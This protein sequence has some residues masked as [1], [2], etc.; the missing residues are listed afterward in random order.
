VEGVCGEHGSTYI[1]TSGRTLRQFAAT[2]Q[3]VDLLTYEHQ[4]Y[5]LSFHDYRYGHDKQ[6]DKIFM[7]QQQ[8]YLLTSCRT[9]GMLVSSDHEAVRA[10]VA[11]SSSRPTRKT[12]RQMLSKRD[13]LTSFAP[14]C[15]DEKKHKALSSIASVYNQMSNNGNEHDNLT[16]AVEKVISKLPISKK[17]PSGWCDLQDGTMLDA[18]ADRNRKSRHYARYKSDETRLMYVTS[19]RKLKKIKKAARN[20]WLL[21]QVKDSNCSLLP[22]GHNRTGVGAVWNFVRKCKRGNRKWKAWKFSNICDSNG[23]MGTSPSTNATNF[24]AYYEKLFTNEPTA[25]RPDNSARWYSQMTQYHN[26]REWGPPTEDEVLR[27]VGENKNTAPGMTGI[28]TMVWKTI[29]EDEYLRSVIMRVMVKCWESETVPVSWTQFYMTVIEKDGDLSNPKNYRG[30]AIAEAMSKIYTTVLKFRLNAVYE[31]MAPE[32]ANGFRK[33]RGRADSITSV[34]TTLRKRKA[35]GL[36]SHLLLFDIVKCFDSIKRQHIW[37]SMRKMGISEKLIRIV[38]STLYSTTAILHVEGEQREVRV[39]EGTGQGTTLGPILCNLFLLPLL[40]H[41]GALWTSSATKLKHPDHDEV[42]DS[43]IHNFADDMAIITTSRAEAETTA[44]KIYLYLQDFLIDLHVATPDI[45]RS[46][47]VVLF[48]PAIDGAPEEGNL[49]PLTVDEVH[50]K[51]INFV[52]EVKYLGHI[53]T[54]NLTD[55]A[56]LHSRMG[57]AAQVFG[58]LRPNLFAKKEVWNLVK[59]KIMETMIIPTLLDGT[60][61]CAISATTMNEM[62]SLY[63]DLSE[64]V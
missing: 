36:N 4:E 38:Q 1:N 12:S 32:F 39:Q 53:I 23:V 59:A 54:S 49:E 13:I 61:C 42:T 40:L 7:R 15:S 20:E 41:W 44:S 58:A 45:E 11:I 30:I 50:G 34:M 14:S 51:K 63:L 31:D 57:K 27:A 10:D 2:H 18:I 24:K 35:W 3:L 64:P 62:E 52:Q 9:I 5:R 19:R 22:G 56:H 46:K 26:G 25:T 48:I 8:Q 29:L 33:G 60:E 47:S 17:S 37:T 55:E 28:P 16:K 43:F 6:L 21:S